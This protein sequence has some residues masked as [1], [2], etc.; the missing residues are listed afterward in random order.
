ML[1]QPK[2]TSQN[3][4]YFVVICLLYFCCVKSADFCRQNWNLS[5]TV[6]ILRALIIT[7]KEYFC[8]RL[9][10]YLGP[11]SLS[12]WA[13]EEKRIGEIGTLLAVLVK[14]AS[15]AA[16]GLWGQFGSR[17]SIQWPSNICFHVLWGSENHHSLNEKTNRQ[18][19]LLSETMCTLW[20]ISQRPVIPSLGHQRYI[21]C[22]NMTNKLTW[23]G[24]Y[25]RRHGIGERSRH[26]RQ[27]TPP[28]VP[29]SARFLSLIFASRNWADGGTRYQVI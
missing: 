11:V 27:K 8:L 18:C 25:W 17:K 24:H 28:K 12:H 26:W 1:V 9:G 13:K 14:S 29:G 16:D 19:K 20:K 5:K 6:I 15:E 2:A 21:W 10:L 23:T 3:D 22:K 7:M 4:S